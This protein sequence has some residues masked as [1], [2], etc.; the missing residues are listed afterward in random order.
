M[1][2]DISDNESGECENINPAPLSYRKTLT[3]EPPPLNLYL[4]DKQPVAN[5]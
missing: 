5:S 1:N 4:A 3:Q 2:V